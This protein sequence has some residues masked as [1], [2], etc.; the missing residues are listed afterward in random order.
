MNVITIGTDRSIFKEGSAVRERLIEYGGLVG[1]LHVVVFAPKGFSGQKLADNVWVY[2]TNSNSKLSYIRDAK[3]VAVAIINDKKFTP[4]ETI[5]SVQDPFE[6]GLVGLF[7]KKRFGFKLQ[8]QVHTDFLSQY[9]FWHS[10]F[11]FFRS[12]IAWRI[13]PKADQIRVVS[14]RIERSLAAHPSRIS[15][16]KIAVLPI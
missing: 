8:V 4:V 7:L 15:R 16:K 12:F 1:E 10:T 13:L 5:I 11:N 6:T 9:F 14:H 2:P 3:Q